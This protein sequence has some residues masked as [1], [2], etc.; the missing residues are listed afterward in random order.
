[1]KGDVIELTLGA[2]QTLILLSVFAP[3]PA[4][5]RKTSINDTD[6]ANDL[7]TVET[8]AAGVGIVIATYVAVHT[9]SIEPLIVSGMAIAGLLWMYESQLRK[10]SPNPINNKEYRSEYSNVPLT[11]LNQGNE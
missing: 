3:N 6:F 9:K 10:S 7:R 8:V 4:T 5:V 11:D 2:T 1:M